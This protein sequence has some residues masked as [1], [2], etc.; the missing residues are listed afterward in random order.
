[1]GIKFNKLEKKERT[2]ESPHLESRSVEK[3]VNML[4]LC[5]V[6]SSRRSYLWS[7]TRFPVSGLL[8]G[9]VRD[10][11]GRVIPLVHIFEHQHDS[12]TT[13]TIRNF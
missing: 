2:I 4:K 1:M 8:R 3:K 13:G 9:V 5:K 12:N 11:R 7:K 10:V 6:Q